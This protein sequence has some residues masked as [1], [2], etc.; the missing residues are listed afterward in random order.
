MRIY[1]ADIHS[2]LISLNEANRHYLIHVMRSK[3][4]DLCYV[5][6]GQGLEVKA[7]ISHISKKE[8]ILTVLETIPNHKESPLKIHLFQAFCKGEKMDWIMQKS[9]ELGVSEITPIISER[10]EIKINEER[11]EKKYQHFRNILIHASAQSGRSVL[12]KLNP[13]LSLGQA[14]EN[15][16]A[17]LNIMF[18]PGVEKTLSQIKNDIIKTP[19]QI[20]IFI[21]P[22][23]GM[24]ETEIN[25]AK[26]ASVHLASLGKRILRTETAPLAAIVSLQILWGDFI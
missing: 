23:G 10:C 11:L 5:F 17:C 7:K 25:A 15:K 18:T 8:V 26:Q 22:E 14:I 6:D 13:A 21:G 20:S 3:L 16:A 1:Q 2:S 9:V 19:K 12:T 4:N 24:S